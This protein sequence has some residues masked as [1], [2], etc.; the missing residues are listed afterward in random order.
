MTTRHVHVVHGGRD[1]FV[2]QQALQS[3]EIRAPF[4]QVGGKGVAQGVSAAPFVMPA[5]ALAA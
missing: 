4:Q 2:P 1:T 3:R 5:R